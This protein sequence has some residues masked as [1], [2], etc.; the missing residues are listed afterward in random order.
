MYVLSVLAS[1]ALTILRVGVTRYIG[2]VSNFHC[3]R[4][5]CAKIS[6]EHW[7]P[8]SL[9]QR[10]A[11]DHVN[12]EI[13]H[14]KGAY[15]GVYRFLPGTYYRRRAGAQDHC[16]SR[17]SAIPQRRSRVIRRETVWFV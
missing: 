16:A 14:R 10:L 17:P 13:P 12:V 4:L 9:T 7:K 15:V 8:Y 11:Y 5:A 6:L 1:L 3:W 2:Y